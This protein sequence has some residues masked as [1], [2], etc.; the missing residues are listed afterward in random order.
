MLGSACLVGC[1]RLI[2]RP[3]SALEH[4]MPDWL[5]T[6]WY[7]VLAFGS[8]VSL[9]GVFWR[10]PSTGLLIERAGMWF[11]SSSALVY[12]IAL[13]G[14]GGSRAL[15]AASFV[16]GF[17]AASAL[18]S[19]DVSR[20]LVKVRGMELAREAVLRPEGADDEM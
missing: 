15:A 18:R 12:T 16:G 2:S 13:F 14:V 4:A 3:S 7:V 20:I 8:I 5:V 10:E 6:A 17:S 9:V 1:S 11:L 19:V